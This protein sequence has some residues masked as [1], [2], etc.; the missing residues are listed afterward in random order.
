ALQ[1]IIPSPGSLAMLGLGTGLLCRRQ[2]AT[3]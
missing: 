2:R 3:R 1:T